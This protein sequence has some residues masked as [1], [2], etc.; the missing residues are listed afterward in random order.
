[1]IN[2][3]YTL[4][5]SQYSQRISEWKGWTF[6]GYCFLFP[7]CR[8]QCRCRSLGCLL[9][10]CHSQKLSLWTFYSFFVHGSIL[11]ILVVFFFTKSLST[12]SLLIKPLL[13]PNSARPSRSVF[14]ERGLVT[15][16]RHVVVVHTQLARRC[17]SRELCFYFEVTVLGE[18]RIEYL[19]KW[20]CYATNQ[21][22]A[23]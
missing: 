8:F 20:Q 9:L 15:S 2:V 17:L 6:Q 7:N 5:C 19:W 23:L 12:F 18:S 11:S 21:K 3:P 4:E 16:S 14:N 13:T 10:H 1:M 22:H